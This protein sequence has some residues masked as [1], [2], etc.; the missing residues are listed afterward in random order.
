[1]TTNLLELTSFVVQGFKN[2]LQTDV[3]TLHCFGKA[4]DSVN[5]SLLVRKVDLLGFNV[6]LL[7]YVQSSAPKL[8]TSVN[9][10]HCQINN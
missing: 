3:T 4:F 9:T 7:L 2:N 6:I 1:M 5:N 8:L 10:L